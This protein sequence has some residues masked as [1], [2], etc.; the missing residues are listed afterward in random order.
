MAS[1]GQSLAPTAE[2]RADYDRKHRIAWV[3]W[4][5]FLV[6]A[7]AEMAFFAF[8]DPGEIMLFGNP[9]DLSPTATYSIFFLFFWA[10]GVCSSALTCFLQKSP[11]ELNRCPIPPD[12]RPEGC[13]KRGGGSCCD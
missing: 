9:L 8:I 3:L 6:G 7:A 4:P 2:R 10:V 11:F 12:S 13:P 5:S 1:A